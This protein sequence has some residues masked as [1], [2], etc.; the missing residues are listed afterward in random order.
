MAADGHP[1]PIAPGRAGAPGPWRALVQ[2][3]RR[4]LAGLV[5]AYQLL[6]S[7]WLGN[8]CRYAPS[9][10]HYALQALNRHGALGGTALATWR[11][12]R[13]NPWSLGGED[14]VPPQHPFAGLFTRL[15]LRA[16]DDSPDPEKPS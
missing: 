4:L 9:C 6:F 10:S 13:C 5:R 14:P 3:P 2:L 16:G 15:P 12:L 8:V 11:V 1:A 7:A